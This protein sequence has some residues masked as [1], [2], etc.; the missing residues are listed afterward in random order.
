MQIVGA[1]GECLAVEPHLA[2][3]G[4][5]VAVGVGEL[6]D[7]RRG[8]DVERAVEPERALGEHHFVGKDG[9]LV[10]LAVAVRV[11]EADDAV[12]FVG[13]LLFD[14]VVRA[15]AVGDVEFAR[16]AKGHGDGP[17]HER[18]A[19]GEFHGQAVGEGESVEADFEFG[20][21]DGGGGE[22]G[23]EGEEREAHGAD[24]RRGRGVA[25]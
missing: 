4:H 3:V 22:E 12:R 5:A 18:R 6:P 15:R 14:L 20:G 13:E 19:G 10:E 1:A 8:G 9:A 11:H 17:V 25:Q 24:E 21:V 23:E 7:L 16:V 2:L